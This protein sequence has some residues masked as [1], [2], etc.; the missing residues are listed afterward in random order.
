M[1]Q[2]TATEL[3]TQTEIQAMAGVLERRY[4]ARASEVARH[5]VVEHETIGDSSRASIWSGVCALL[6]QMATPR[7]LS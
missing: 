1:T 2:I 7:T 5:F 6:E 3:P 4:G